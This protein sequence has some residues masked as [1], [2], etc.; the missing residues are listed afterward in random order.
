MLAPRRQR[1]RLDPA[2]SDLASSD[3]IERQREYWRR[4]P[5]KR[6][7]Q[8]ERPGPGQESVWDYP[9]PPRVERVPERVRVELAGEVLAE[10]Q[11]ALRVCETASPPAYYLPAADV[12][13]EWLEASDLTSLCE[14]K[15][16]AHYWSARV[17]K[18]LAAEAAW[19]Y[20]DPDPD[21]A[22][23]RDHFAFFAG[24]VDACR[25]GDA[26]ATPQPGGFYGGWI[27]PDLVGPF[28][29]EPGSQG[30]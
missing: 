3:D 28:K 8:I 25:V 30:W 14:W 6:P 15:G 24:R 7:A 5:R 18:R 22:G 11:D 4:L 26:R 23:L 16:V 27:T 29:G 17:G 13:T 2:G 19:S 9:R 10:S 20:P 21:Y 12:R 1:A